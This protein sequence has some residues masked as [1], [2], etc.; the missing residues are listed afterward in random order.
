M[1]RISWAPL[2]GFVWLTN[3][4]LHVR[5]VGVDVPNGREGGR[6]RESRSEKRGHW[7]LLVW[8]GRPHRG[9]SARPAA[10]L[11]L[12][13]PPRWPHPDPR[14]RATIPL[15]ADEFR[16]LLRVRERSRTYRRPGKKECDH[17]IP[18]GQRDRAIV[19]LLLDTGMPRL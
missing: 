14:P 1:S 18:T 16:S 6:R 13:P 12:R 3:N 17:H 19:L 15:T 8:L 4:S 11:A 9:P 5:A 2:P 10:A 7:A